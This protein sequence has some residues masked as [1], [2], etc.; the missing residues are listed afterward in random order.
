MSFYRLA[1]T[2]KDGQTQY[3]EI[4]RVYNGKR[5]AS[6]IISPNPVRGNITAFVSISQPQKINVT[7]MD[8]HG[9]IL[10]QSQSHYDEGL[11]EITI[12]AMQ[13]APGNYLLQLKGATVNTVEKVIKQ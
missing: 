11:Q 12:D 6:V 13:L 1:Q 10:K 4:K 7:L 9:R 2:D 5:N 8:M 3:F